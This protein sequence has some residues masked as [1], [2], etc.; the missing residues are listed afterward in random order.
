MT[1]YTSLMHEHLYINMKWLRYQ[2]VISLE[3]QEGIT[4]QRNKC[5]NTDP[6]IYRRWGQVPRRSKHPMSSGHT[7]R[8]PIYTPLIHEHLYTNI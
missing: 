8:E 4:S 7:R 3:T 6:R 5:S 2:I 1:I